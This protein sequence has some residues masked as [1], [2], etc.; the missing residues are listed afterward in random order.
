MS[1]KLIGRNWCQVAVLLLFVV[2][3]V[4]VIQLSD[5]DETLSTTPLPPTPAPESEVIQLV[6]SPA[7]AMH[8]FLWW[9]AAIA[10][11][12]LYAIREGLHFYWVKQMFS[13]RDIEGFA[14]GSFDWRNADRVVEQAEKYGLFLLARLDREPYWAREDGAEENGPPADYQDFGNYCFAVAE[15]YRGRI[16]AYQIWN[17]PNLTREWGG[18]PPNPAEYTRLL[19]TCYEGI[20]RGDPDAI[21]ISAG[22]APT[23]TGLPIAMP[24]DEFLK[25]MY[26][27]GAGDYF[28]MLGVNAPGYAAP[29]EASPDEAANKPEWGGHRWATF[30]H[31]E[32]I[33]A[34]MVAEGDGHKQ[35]SILEMGWT[36]DPVH[37]EYS[38]YAVTQEQQA[39]YL[40]GAY[41][42]A[43]LHWR[44]W[45]GIMTTIYM[46]DINWTP[47][48]E[49]YWW[50]I[51]EPVYPLT[52]WKPAFKAL[53]TLPDWSNG[54]YDQ[55]YLAGNFAPPQPSE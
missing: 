33:R 15:R 29:P 20:K 10:E 34:I 4:L 45:I 14:E 21:V 7:P 32:D 5:L 47:E 31:V 51:I 26:E 23:G 24:D 19:A 41:W 8:A 3:V 54:F 2:L 53:G 13:W 44:P 12:D 38:W 9:D 50:A 55:W 43:R 22:L 39:E 37:P 30:R 1:N 27:A 16:K 28:D 42:W 46:P 40:L 6:P 18:K 52:V 49:Q 36:T 25:G 48:D 11:R 35:I 17:E